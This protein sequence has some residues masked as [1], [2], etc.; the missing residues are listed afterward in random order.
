MIYYLDSDYRVHTEPGEALVSWEDA[1]GIFDGKCKAYV[2]G[3]RVV[4][5]GECWKR[6]DGTVFKGLMV[7]PVADI[8]VLQT[9]QTDYEK[10]QAEVEDMKSALAL[11]GVT[12]D[13]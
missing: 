10:V 12:L 1:N 7:S 5:E 2:E 3:F 6:G 4:P 11:L 13:E 9:A 8:G